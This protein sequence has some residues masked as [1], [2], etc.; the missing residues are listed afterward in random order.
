[1]GHCAFWAA[2]L[3][4]DNAKSLDEGTPPLAF[5]TAESWS[6]LQSSHTPGSDRSFKPYLTNIFQCGVVSFDR[7]QHMDWHQMQ[8]FAATWTNLPALFRFEES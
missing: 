8:L 7:F 2:L 4:P 3:D 6:R 1:M 5:L